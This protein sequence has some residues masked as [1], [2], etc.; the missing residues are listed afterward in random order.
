MERATDEQ[1]NERLRI[2]EHTDELANQVQQY[3]KELD[4]DLRERA[5]AYA[6]EWNQEQMQKLRKKIE[7][8]SSFFGKWL[9]KQKK[10]Q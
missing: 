9:A 2:W 3:Q 7:S 6:K 5:L 4:F 10:K 1:L 8:P